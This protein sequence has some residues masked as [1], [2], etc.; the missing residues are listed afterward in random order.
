MNKIAALL[1]ENGIVI[2]RIV[3]DNVEDFPNAIDGELC[4]IGDKWDGQSFI[5][6]VVPEV[7]KIEI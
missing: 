4:S 7:P 1:D 6:S 2:N 3:V 5:K